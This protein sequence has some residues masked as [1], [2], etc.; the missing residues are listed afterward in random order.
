MW[1]KYCALYWDFVNHAGVTKAMFNLTDAGFPDNNGKSHGDNIY[2]YW[3]STAPSDVEIG[4]TGYPSGK[5]PWT[6]DVSVWGQ[7]PNNKRGCTSTITSKSRCTKKPKKPCPACPAYELK[8]VCSISKYTDENNCKKHGGNWEIK[9]TIPPG[10][11]CPNNMEQMINYVLWV[12]NQQKSNGKSN[13]ISFIVIDGEGE[14]YSMDKKGLCSLVE[15]TNQA[16][17]DKKL[18]HNFTLGIAHGPGTY[19]TDDKNDP[20]YAKSTCAVTGLDTAYPEIYWFGELVDCAKA[21]NTKG[22]QAGYVSQACTNTVYQ[23]YLNDPQGL[24]DAI[25]T[26]GTPGGAKLAGALG[27][28]TSTCKNTAV[29]P[30]SHDTCVNGYCIYNYDKDKGDPNVYRYSNTY[31][32]F[33]LEN[34]SANK[35]TKNG[36]YYKCGNTQ[37]VKGGDNSQCCISNVF[38]G[39]QFSCGSFNGFGNWE[40]DKFQEFMNDWSKE[41]GSKSLAIYEWQFVPTAWIP[42]YDAIMGGDTFENYGDKPCSGNLTWLWITLGVLLLVLVGIYLATRG[43]SKKRKGKR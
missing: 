35:P 12:N 5:T 7:D 24:F 3:V 18:P 40:W 19:C 25:T 15:A 13:M 31:P 8:G 21:V 16:K 10:P 22:K 29:C 43:G 4:F 41:F 34:I 33:S 14:G 30:D 9:P 1:K 36:D 38:S 27:K 37:N 6:W 42:N 11:G 39:E 32:M 23:K 26:P 28:T 17:N 20:N 2:N